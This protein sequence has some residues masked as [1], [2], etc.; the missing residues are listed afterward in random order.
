MK[1]IDD[2]LYTELKKLRIDKVLIPFIGAGFSANV[3]G[4]PEWDEF[5]GIL[6]DILNE[7]LEENEEIVNFKRMFGENDPAECTQ[8]FYWHKGQENGKS[9]ANILKKGKDE[10]RLIVFRK[11][12][13]PTYPRFKC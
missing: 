9:I 2:V 5:M 1:I 13:P 3:S 6:Q 7:E 12:E 11:F 10:F 4:Y 8:Y